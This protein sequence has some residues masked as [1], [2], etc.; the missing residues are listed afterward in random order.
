MVAVGTLLV[1][2][3]VVGVTLSRPGP[4]PDNTIDLSDGLFWLRDEAAG[5]AVQ[6]NPATG[7]REDAVAVAPPGESWQLAQRDGLL[8]VTTVDGL[9]SVIDIATLSTRGWYEG[10]PAT[11]VLLDEESLYVADRGAGRI[12]RLDPGDASP[13]GE[14]WVA[15]APLADVAMDGAGTIWALRADGD[16]HR[17]AWNGSRLVDVEPRQAIA[18]A[19]PASL[20]V[21]HPRGVTVLVPENG[22]AVRIATGPGGTG[23]DA[24]VAA[25][26]LRG[27][28]LPAKRAPVDLVPVSI[29]D[30]ATVVLIA[31]SVTHTVLTSA[32]GCENPGEPVA[33]DGLAYVPCLGAGRVIVLDST[34]ALVPPDLVLGDDGDTE[35]TVLDDG[36]VAYLPASGIGLIRHTDGSL[37]PLDAT[38]TADIPTTAAT[39]PGPPV[40]PTRTNRGGGGTGPT[41]IVTTV[42]TPPPPPP[43][44]VPVAGDHVVLGLSDVE[45]TVDQDGGP[46]NA[47]RC[48]VTYHRY[49]LNLGFLPTWQ[50]PG[51]TCQLVVTGSGSLARPPQTIPCTATTVSIGDG[52]GL[53]YSFKVVSLPSNVS[54]NSISRTTIE[55]FGLELCGEYL[56]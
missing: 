26:G 36:V 32:Y 19:G 2:G 45:R 5:E 14:P 48:R 6:I 24:T 25:P 54:S 8:V 22:T 7:R 46:C 29:V 38:L 15:G 21:A 35:V 31:G 44:A 13:E 55:P 11:K 53:T 12:E 16:L 20:L 18:G 1:A 39:A 47:S 10:G 56:C 9:V 40:S 33:L 34:G 43:P 28:L 42:G 52:D 37:T 50:A 27:R 3:V 51:L 49:T 4:G 30:S 41:T 17:L 23:V